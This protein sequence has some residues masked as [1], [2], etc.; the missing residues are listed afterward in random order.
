MCDLFSP[1]V[2]LDPLFSFFQLKIYFHPFQ[3]LP[4][5]FFFFKGSVKLGSAIKML[6]NKEGK[7]VRNQMENMLAK[8]PPMD[9]LLCQTQ[10]F[11]NEQK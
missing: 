6:M 1:L 3:P 11:L 9:K 2:K 10:T 7:F 8:K 4:K 5:N